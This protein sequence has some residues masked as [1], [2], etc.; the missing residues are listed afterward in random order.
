VNAAAPKAAFEPSAQERL[1]Q[2]REQ[3]A[4]WLEKQGAVDEGAADPDQG[5]LPGATTGLRGLSSNPVT[6][7]GLDFLTQWWNQ[8]PL[9]KSARNAEDAARDAI[10]PLVRRHP[11]AVLGTAAAAG[12]L[13]VWCR[14]WRWLPRPA[15]LASLASTIAIGEISRIALQRTEESS[16]AD[17]QGPH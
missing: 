10:A 16:P 7:I 12:A 8:H 13:L 11:V 6:L 17:L 15:K 1:V 4:R 2:S 5:Q 9:L 3:M 14:P